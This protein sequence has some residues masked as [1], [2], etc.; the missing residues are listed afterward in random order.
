MRIFLIGDS[1]SIHYGPYLEE[2]LRGTADYSRKGGMDAALKDLDSA[3]GANGGDSSNVLAYM[4]AKASTGGFDADLLMVNCGLHDVKTNPL[5]GAKQIPEEKYSENLEG[6]VHTAA[7]IGLPMIWISTTPCEEKVHNAISKSFFRYSHDVV[8]YNKIA[9]RVMAS[10]GVP[11]LDLYTFT[12]NCGKELYCDHVHFSDAVR[13]LQ[14]AFIAGWIACHE[15]SV[16]N[17]K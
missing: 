8:A 6:I 14:A 17:R 12:L 1:I 4:R 16:F 7:S 10:A 15:S 13:R 9:A 2:Y 3:L 11:V 5:T